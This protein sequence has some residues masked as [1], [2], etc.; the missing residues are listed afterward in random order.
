MQYP[1]TRKVYEEE[2]TLL[3]KLIVY[4][5]LKKREKRSNTQI[6]NI[7]IYVVR[8]YAYIHGRRKGES[9]TKKLVRLQQWY[10]DSLKEPKPQIHPNLSLT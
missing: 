7:K 5:R 4:A 6:K 2:A 10:Q 3:W 1:S 9:F 8:K